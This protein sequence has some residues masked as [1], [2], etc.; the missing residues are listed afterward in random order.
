MEKLRVDDVADWLWD[1]SKRFFIVEGMFD[2]AF[3]LPVEQA[4]EKKGLQRVKAV[5]H[6][7][8]LTSEIFKNFKDMMFDHRIVLYDWPIPEG[9]AHCDYISEL[10]ELQAEIHS[11][12]VITVEAPQVDGKHDD[13]SDALVRMVWLATKH[14]SNAKKFAGSGSDK[15]PV[16]IVQRSVGLARARRRALLGG[17]HPSRQPIVVAMKNRAQ[18]R[19]WRQS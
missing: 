4:I 1:L 12:Y 2:Q 3:G 9:K 5:H 14:M 16:K 18:G 10:L 8:T 13:Y 6:T 11:K 19:W 17:S 15:L 7:K